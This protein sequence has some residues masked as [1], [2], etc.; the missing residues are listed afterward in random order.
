MKSKK[1]LLL[2][3]T[4]MAA[5]LLTV[6]TFAKPKLNR[7]SATIQAGKTI[8]LKVKGAKNKKSDGVHQT[9]RL[10]S[11]NVKKQMQQF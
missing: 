10:L 3:L 5:I 9:K 11:L 1:K 6:P 2:I 7:K 4:V 8:K